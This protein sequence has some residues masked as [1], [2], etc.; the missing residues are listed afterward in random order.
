MG[1]KNKKTNRQ[2]HQSSN[3]ICCSSK[4]Q[5]TNKRKLGLDNLTREQT[6]V[7]VVVGTLG[8]D[9]N[10]PSKDTGSTENPNKNQNHPINSLVKISKNTEESTDGTCW[11]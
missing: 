1:V 4:L 7:P 8:T 3:G 2:F 9:L 6:I 10:Y 11:H 5:S